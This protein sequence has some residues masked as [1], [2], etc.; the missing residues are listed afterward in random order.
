MPHE[1]A[2]R[3]SK[4]Y[5]TDEASSTIRVID[6][7]TGVI[8]RVAGNGLSGLVKDSGPATDTPLGQ[9]WGLAVDRGGSVFFA[10]AN[11][12]RVMRVDGTNGSI[13]RAIGGQ[14]GFGGDG[15]MAF[16]A[17]ISTPQGV[18]IDR[19]GNLYFAD[20]SNNRIRVALCFAPPEDGQASD[21]EVRPSAAGVRRVLV[22]WY[23]PG[24]YNCVAGGAWAGPRA[25]TGA[26]WIAPLVNGVNRYTLT[27]N[28][29]E[30]AKFTVESVVDTTV[31]TTKAIDPATDSK[32]TKAPG[33]SSKIG[34]AHV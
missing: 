29:S 16:A 13:S 34:R 21:C 8:T 9:I 1:L 10:E 26:E 7:V 32:S 19:R 5:F 12:H 22:S 20:R 33:A 27:C 4:L 3:G 25:S 14:R 24:A 30:S 17:A 31:V 6:L 28:T 2:V 23:Q 15:G 11:T 18:A